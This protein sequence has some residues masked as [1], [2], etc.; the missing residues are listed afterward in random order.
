MVIRRIRDHVSSHNW[1]AVVVDLAIV[2]AG[3]FLGIQASNWNS[4]RIERGEVRAYRSQI[5]ND[6]KANERAVVARQAYF[7]QVRSHA[8]AALRAVEAGSGNDESFLV[9]A[10]QA[11]QGWPV[12]MERAAYDE[13]LSS[14]TSK[15][16]GDSL[17]RQQMSSYYAMLPTFEATVTAATGYRELVRRSMKFAVQQRIRERCND[18]IRTFPDGFQLFSLPRHCSLDLPSDQL[19]AAAARLEAI[20]ELEPELTRHIGDL[21]QK[22]SLLG[23]RHRLARE[24][25]LRLQA[26][27]E[28]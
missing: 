17:T 21:D 2:V 20:V 4:A 27:Q 23:R 19:A 10:Y 16:F 1:F 7:E 24:L 9:D 8:L 5:I 3:V 6:L 28:D 11:S 22:I 14:G 13:M 12:R 26:I 18:I 25:R 15:S